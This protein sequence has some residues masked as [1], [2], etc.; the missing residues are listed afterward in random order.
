MIGLMFMLRAKH[1]ET[2]REK[3]TR[4]V[5]R[6]ET[7][8]REVQYIDKE[9][10]ELLPEDPASLAA[11]HPLPTVPDGTL[12][13]RI[14]ALLNIDPVVA[15][16]PAMIAMRLSELK[17]IDSVRSTLIRLYGEGR[18]DR[19]DPGRYRSKQLSLGVPN[20]NGFGGRPTPAENQT[21][22]R[23]K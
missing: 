7:L 6:R 1:M 20:G 12:T 2:R 23:V 10:D 19:P 4:L 3:V 15:L 17:R 14:I 8:T 16:T 18:I 21:G 11:S 22:A 13:E 9:L 5:L